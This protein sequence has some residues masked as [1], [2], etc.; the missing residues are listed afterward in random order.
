MSVHKWEPSQ[1]ST[2]L[3]H[4]RQADGLYKIL[5]LLQGLNVYV[6]GG[7]VRDFAL[8]QSPVEINDIDLMVDAPATEI[9]R[10]TDSA[11]R[12]ERTRFGNR[13]YF[14]DELERT[15]DVFPVATQRCERCTVEQALWCCDFSVNAIAVRLDN[16]IFYDPVDGMRDVDELRCRP[17]ADGW[18]MPGE[19][20]AF[21]LERFCDLVVRVPFRDILWGIPDTVATELATRH[22]MDY[23]DLLERYRAVRQ[24]YI[25]RAYYDDYLD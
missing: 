3:K 21:L 8:G 25:T 18:D 14:V 1:F 13:T 9:F 4:T 19:G 7:A 24:G 17:L 6:V 22:S 10:R 16:F 20:R 23:E 5:G 11:F 12:H 15:V 2:W